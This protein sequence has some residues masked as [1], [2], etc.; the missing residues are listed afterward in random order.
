MEA[1]F[2][3]KARSRKTAVASLVVSLLA[4]SAVAQE[5]PTKQDLRTFQVWSKAVKDEFLFY[6]TR[7]D[8]LLNVRKVDEADLKESLTRNLHFDLQPDD[9]AMGR[10][11]TVKPQ[12]WDVD[13]CRIAILGFRRIAATVQQVGS[14]TDRRY[15]GD[16]RD[17]LDRAVKCEAGLSLPAPANRFRDVVRSF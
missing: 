2:P 4:G 11:A 3:I 8:D 15:V 6:R 16:A 1:N 17:Y 9:R 5:R 7:E 10:I 13:N 14:V 12:V